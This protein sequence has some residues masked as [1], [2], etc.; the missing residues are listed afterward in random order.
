MA[1]VCFLWKLFIS[2]IAPN[3]HLFAVKSHV[4]DFPL[5][6]PILKSLSS[7]DRIWYLKQIFMKSFIIY[8]PLRNCP[9]IMMQNDILKKNLKYKALKKSWIS[10]CL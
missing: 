8:D 5:Y 4:E 1:Y 7:M 2:G 10:G 9:L 3:D 6:G